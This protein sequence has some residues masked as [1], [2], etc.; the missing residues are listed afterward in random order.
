MNTTTPKFQR[1]YLLSVQS[2]VDRTQY[3]SLTPP[4][5]LE[6]DINR[7]MNSNANTGRFRIYNLAKDTRN[8]MFHVRYDTSKAHYQRIQMFAGYL[9][10]NIRPLI[11]IG[12]VR[13]CGTQRQ[14]PDWI[15]DIDAFDG[16][17]GMLVGQAFIERKAGWTASDVLKTL[18]GTM[19][20]TQFGAV[21]DISIQNTRGLSMAGNSWD[22]CSRL[23]GKN[24]AYIDLNKA[25]FHKE[26][27]YLKRPGQIEL[28]LGS[29]N[30]IGTPKREAAI[31]EVDMIFEPS[32]FMGQAV[33]LQ[34]LQSIYDGTYQVR[35]IRHRGTISGAICGE[36][37]TT[38]TLWT[39]TAGLTEVAAQ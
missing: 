34:S 26:N 28:I 18:V 20:F 15:T 6:F 5:T 30:I 27:E 33:K 17:V 11:F 14:G 8:G 36:A 21:G 1:T 39:G 12:N 35:G 29:D 7:T 37:T 38:L 23:V 31:I 10:N 3:F 9:T 24:L 32:V 16:G 19:P 13:V 2:T 22:V 25:Y 4:F